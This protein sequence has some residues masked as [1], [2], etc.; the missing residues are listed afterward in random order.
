L[1][2]SIKRYSAISG[3]YLLFPPI[4]TQMTGYDIAHFTRLFEDRDSLIQMYS[5]DVLTIGALVKIINNAVELIHYDLTEN[6][7]ES[8]RKKVTDNKETWNHLM[9]VFNK[10][11]E[12]IGAKYISL[13]S[14]ELTSADGLF[15]ISGLQTTF[16][17][18]GVNI[19]TPNLTGS[20]ASLRNDAI[21]YLL[22]NNSLGV[23]IGDRIFTMRAHHIPYIVTATLPTVHLDQCLPLKTSLNATAEKWFWYRMYRMDNKLFAIL[24]K[25]DYT[26]GVLNQLDTVYETLKAIKQ[27]KINGNH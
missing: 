16:Q 19:V 15:G 24:D 3:N 26:I 2:T 22:A 25:L 5:E 10:L 23:K 8:I 21:S 7:L 18:K 6:V 17:D 9:I 13:V 4:D 20:V 1:I 27:E 14:I 12:V 11:G